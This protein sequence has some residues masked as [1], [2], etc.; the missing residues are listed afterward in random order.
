LEVNSFLFSTTKASS[1]LLASIAYPTFTR[2][3]TYDVMGRV[4][5]AVDEEGSETR[6]EYDGLNRLV[7][8]ADATGNE[9]CEAMTSAATWFGC[10]TPTRATPSLITTRTTD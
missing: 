3:L 1:R 9:V 4:T 10:R 2:H 6:Y 8:T 5:A 7:K